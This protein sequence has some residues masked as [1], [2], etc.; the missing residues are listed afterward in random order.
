MKSVEGREHKLPIELSIVPALYEYDLIIGLTNNNLDFK[1]TERL[2]DLIYNQWTEGNYPEGMG[3]SIHEQRAGRLLVSCY[4]E[5]QAKLFDL[6]WL[7]L[8]S[9]EEFYLVDKRNNKEEA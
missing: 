9:S 2:S 4:K 6:V 5:H 8:N 7:A 3:F 1:G